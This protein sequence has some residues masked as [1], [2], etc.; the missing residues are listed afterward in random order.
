MS[1]LELTAR[2]A[3]NLTSWNHTAHDDK[4]DNDVLEGSE[5]KK[6]MNLLAEDRVEQINNGSIDIIHFPRTCKEN[7]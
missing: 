7:S 5:I 2:E 1:S 4:D 3:E 6:V